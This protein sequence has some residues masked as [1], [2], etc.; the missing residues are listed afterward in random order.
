[1][2]KILKTL[3]GIVIVIV[4]IVFIS[5]L[6]NKKYNSIIKIGI[7]G[8]FSGAA[9]SVGEEIRNTILLASSSKTSFLFEDDQCD[10]KKAISSYQ[11]L[12]LEDVHVYYVACSGSVLALAP[13]VKQD[14]NLI[15]TAYAGSSQIR[16][17]GDEVIRFIPDALSIADKMA[18]YSWQLASSSKIGLF[19]EKQDY[20]VSVANNI[21]SSLGS[22]LKYEDTYSGEGN[23][24]KTQIAKLKSAQISHLISIP[25]TDKSEKI[26]FSEMRDMNFKPFLIGDINVCE[27]ANEPKDYG[28]NSVCFDAAFLNE[29][30]AYQKFKDDYKKIYNN[31]AKSPYYDAI[32]LDIMKMIQRSEIQNDEKLVENLKKYFLDGI[33]G[34]MS[35][36]HFTS[37][38]EVVADPH[39]KMFER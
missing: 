5:T 8:P 15:V 32:T 34:E 23:S 30:P 20:S 39:I 10:S 37:N 6:P 2:S 25:T 27:Y 24:F 28:L 4:I 31:E 35:E 16:D 12:K 13:I 36:Y 26:I 38:G 21:K 22:L 17:T 1:M 18:K 14:N 9:Q 19:Y 29:T 7:I 3:I 33:Q 11:K